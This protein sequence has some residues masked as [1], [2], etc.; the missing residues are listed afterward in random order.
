[1]KLLCAMIFLLTLLAGSWQAAPAAA[2]G[3][4][5]QQA[6]PVCS[7]LPHTATLR[8]APDCAKWVAVMPVAPRV[9]TLPAATWRCDADR[10]GLSGRA[11]GD[12]HWRPPRALA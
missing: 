4:P 7:V 5:S 8:G 10:Q 12:D 9:M 2:Q 11:C 3:C 1:M 6:A